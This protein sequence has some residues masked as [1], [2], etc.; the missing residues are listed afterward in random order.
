MRIPVATENYLEA[1]LV[2]K[3][4][5]GRVRSIDV[6]KSLDYSKPTVSI[7]MKQLREKGYIQM[8]SGGYITLTPE[9]KK[10]AEKT[11]ERHTII[12]GLLMSLGVDEGTAYEDACKIEHDLSEKSFK[13]IKHQFLKHRDRD[14]SSSQSPESL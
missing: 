2:E 11:Y 8:D 10:I 14:D 7:M 9:G 3:A 1:I 12:A 13:A 6:C 5:L 4:R